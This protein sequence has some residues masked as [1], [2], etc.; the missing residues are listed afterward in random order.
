MPSPIKPSILILFLFIGS[1]SFAQRSPDFLNP[2]ST[3]E[4]QALQFKMGFNLGWSFPYSAGLEFSLLFSELIDVNMGVGA[5]LS[6]WK[7]GAGTRIYPLRH[8][9]LSPMIGAYFYHATGLQSINVSINLDEAN[10]RITPDNALLLN[11]GMRLRFGNG[12]YFTAAVGYVFPF[13]GDQ[14]VYMSGSRNEALRNMANAISTS[15]L[16]VNVGILLKLSR[17]HYRD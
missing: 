7:Y 17:G 2:E 10:Y 15:G 14:A 16:S 4:F 6:G 3:S 11:G 13:E 8:S 9:K 1:Q 12:H 5:G